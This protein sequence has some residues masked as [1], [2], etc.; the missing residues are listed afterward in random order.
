MADGLGM[1]G[2]PEACVRAPR[3]R[4]IA[5][6]AGVSRMGGIPQVELPNSGL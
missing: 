3:T 6:I 1:S 4:D 5:P 2:L